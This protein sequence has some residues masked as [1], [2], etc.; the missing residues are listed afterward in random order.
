MERQRSMSQTINYLYGRKNSQEIPN[1]EVRKII[2]IY[3]PGNLE[4]FTPADK[5][6]STN[7]VECEITF[8]RKY[9]T[10]Q[11]GKTNVKNAQG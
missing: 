9:R 7:L 5:I 11:T 4:V 3:Y 10:N 2:S 6:D 1:A 8:K